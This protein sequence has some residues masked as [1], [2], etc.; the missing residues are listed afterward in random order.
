M[1]H[2]MEGVLGL[3][4]EAR[5]HGRLF[6]LN[7]LDLLALSCSCL[8]LVASVAVLVTLHRRYTYAERRKPRNFLVAHTVLADLG[9][10]V[11]DLS[12]LWSNVVGCH[13]P[14]LG[15]SLFYLSSAAITAV[16]MVFA[17]TLVRRQT[18]W[19]TD[20]NRLRCAIAAT[21][22]AAL[23]FTAAPL[24]MAGREI[25]GSDGHWSARAASVRRV[26]ARARRRRASA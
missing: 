9:A 26:R 8:S 11:L 7:D 25:V 6:G 13:L 2:D 22:A 5:H 19:K 12:N 15:S 20:P 16:M 3:R 23:L 1:G 4:D 18:R 21:Y 14:G 24:V 10:S 17:A